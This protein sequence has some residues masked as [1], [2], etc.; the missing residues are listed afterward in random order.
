M[1]LLYDLPSQNDLDT[2]KKIKV[3]AAPPGIKD[4]EFNED[5][6]LIKDSLKLK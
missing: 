2:W 5:L 3:L 1:V 4:I 6:L